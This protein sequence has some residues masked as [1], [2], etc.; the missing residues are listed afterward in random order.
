MRTVKPKHQPAVHTFFGFTEQ[1]SPRVYRK[2]VGSREVLVVCDRDNAGGLSA[3]VWRAEVFVAGGSLAVLWRPTLGAA[4]ATACSQGEAE[5]NA[6]NRGEADW[7][8]E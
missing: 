7:S 3:N 5:A 4:L 8:A 6:R 1:Q 2:Q